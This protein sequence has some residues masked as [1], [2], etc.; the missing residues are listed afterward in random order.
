MLK[1]FGI[2]CIYIGLFVLRSQKMCK[3]QG[4]V[5]IFFCRIKIVFLNIYISYIEAVVPKHFFVCVHAV[6]KVICHEEAK[7]LIPLLFMKPCVTY[8]IIQGVHW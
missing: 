1:V 7:R 3:L 8:V 4:K 2:Q 5:N 6:R